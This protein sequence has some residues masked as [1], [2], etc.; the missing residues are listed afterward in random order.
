MKFEI[1]FQ[2]LIF[3]F[4]SKQLIQFLLEFL[5]SVLD[6]WLM[7]MIIEFHYKTIFLIWELTE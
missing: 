4:Q 2:V 6:S 5:H 1:I 3:Q 7:I